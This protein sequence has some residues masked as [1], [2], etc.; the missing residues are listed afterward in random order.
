MST[1]KAATT[2]VTSAIL[3]EVAMGTLNCTFSVDR[4]FQFHP[5]TIEGQ[6]MHSTCDQGRSWTTTDSTCSRQ[7]DSAV[8]SA[9]S[10][11]QAPSCTLPTTNASFA[12]IITLCLWI[13]TTVMKY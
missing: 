1:P 8:A 3:A 13:L 6:E 9:L 12:S 2:A 7:A 11:S 10:E 5:G 4:N